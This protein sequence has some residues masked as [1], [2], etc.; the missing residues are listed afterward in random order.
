MLLFSA[1]L[2]KFESILFNNDKGTPVTC[3][4][5]SRSNCSKQYKQGE[6]DRIVATEDF[7]MFQ[8]DDN[9]DVIDCKHGAR[10]VRKIFWWIRLRGTRVKTNRLRLC[11]CTR[12]IALGRTLARLRIIEEIRAEKE[13]AFQ[14]N[15]L[16]ILL[17][18]CAQVWTRE[19]C[20]Y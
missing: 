15:L 9:K 14:S 3:R 6:F 8:N 5:K 20:Y 16:S 12:W 4:L 2:S 17:Y 10:T 7:W 13:R 18:F 1:S 11:W 19:S